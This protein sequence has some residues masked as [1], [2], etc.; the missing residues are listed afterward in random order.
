MNIQDVFVVVVEMPV[1]AVV[2]HIHIAVVASV[3]VFDVEFAVV[4]L[5]WM[6]IIDAE[7]DVEAAHSH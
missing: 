6:V 3:V 7:V 4:G 1:V 2:V 5:V